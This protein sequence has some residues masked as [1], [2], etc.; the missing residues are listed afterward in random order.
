MKYDMKIGT[1]LSN[2]MGNENFSDFI[3]AID[4]CYNGWFFFLNYLKHENDHSIG[5][6]VAWNYKYFDVTYYNMDIYSWIYFN[7]NL[8][9]HI[10][11]NPSNSIH[12][13][14]FEQ[15]NILYNI[16]NNGVETLWCGRV[17]V[18]SVES[19][20]QMSSRIL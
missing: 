15:F 16:K 14:I 4:F 13:I 5:M 20:Q 19:K 8:F 9:S 2:L 11:T 7:I 10:Y 18:N 3:S 17:F 12:S 6:S 1:R